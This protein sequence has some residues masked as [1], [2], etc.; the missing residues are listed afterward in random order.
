MFNDTDNG[1]TQYCPMCEEWARK[2]EE[3]EKSNKALIN[4]LDIINDV[5]RN[6]IYN[7]NNIVDGIKEILYL[8]DM[9]DIK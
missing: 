1:Q 8:S 9:R 3:L 6:I 7:H 5:T 4:T 2:Y